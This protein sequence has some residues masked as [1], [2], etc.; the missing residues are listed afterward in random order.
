M[1]RIT[2]GIRLESLGLPLRAALEEAARLGAAGVQFDAVGEL[3]ANA[4]S[5]TGRREVRHLLRARQL[6]LTALGCPL[7]HGLDEFENQQPRLE[8]VRKTMTL[9]HD[10]GTRVVIV[11][12]GP[13]PETEQDPRAAVLRESLLDLSRHGDRSGTVLALETGLESGAALAD[14]LQRFDTAGLGVNY[15][16][17]NLLM[18]RL[19]PLA[20]ARSLA[21]WIVHAHAKDARA[22]TASRAAME[23]PLGHGDLDWLELLAVLAEIEYHGWLTIERESGTSGRADI[24]AGLAFLRRFLS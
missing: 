16:P 15:D 5:Q 22:A 19:D 7:R 10:L 3:A 9:A 2:L 20:A 11:Q 18:N 4:L 13:V 8:H 6:A 17:A 24:A 12:A 23:V 14:W 1:Q 21:G